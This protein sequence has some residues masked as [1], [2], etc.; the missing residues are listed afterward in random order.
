MALFTVSPDT[1]RSRT[2][3]TGIIA[4]ATSLLTLQGP[5]RIIG[6]L[7]GFAAIFMRDA[8]N[9]T[10]TSDTSPETTTDTM[11]TNTTNT[12]TITTPQS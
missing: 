7:S 11:A 5:E 9:T 12:S 2:F 1:L 4:I 6:A 8:I 3:W 10:P